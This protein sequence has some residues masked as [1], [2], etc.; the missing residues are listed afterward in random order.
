MPTSTERQNAINTALTLIPTNVASGAND[1][2]ISNEFYLLVNNIGDY[3][4]KFG[5]YSTNQTYRT[6]TIRYTDISG[7]FVQAEI[8]SYENLILTSGDSI[9]GT[10]ELH[11][12]VSNPTLIFQNTNTETIFDVVALS[13][14]ID[15]YSNAEGEQT[16]EIGYYT[17]SAGKVSSI[18]LGG[19]TRS[20]DVV[21]NIG[22]Q[23]ITDPDVGSF[24][25]SL[26]EIYGNLADNFPS[27]NMSENRF[28]D[29]VA[30]N[31]KY[32]P[33]MISNH[34]E[35]EA[36]GIVIHELLA[37]DVPADNSL[38]N[39]E[40][41]INQ[42]I[43]N[44][45]VEMSATG[46][47]QTFTGYEY[48]VGSDNAEEVATV[49][50]PVISDQDFIDSLHDSAGVSASE[51]KIHEASEETITV[52]K[53]DGTTETVTLNPAERQIV[54][55]E[56]IIVDAETGG[57]VISDVTGTTTLYGT[58]F[59]TRD[60]LVELADGTR[61][62]TSEVTQPVNGAMAANGVTGIYLHTQ[63]DPTGQIVLRQ[64]RI[65]EFTD[66]DGREHITT[67]T[68]TLG[69]QTLIQ[70]TV[71][72]ADGV[73]SES[74]A[75][76]VPNQELI[77]NL[78]FIGATAGG[79]LADHLADG[80]VLKGIAY[81]AIIT[82]ITDHFGSFTGYL[83][84]GGTLDAA[85][86]YA[87]GVEISNPVAGT[88]LE[89]AEI[90]GTFTKHLA[91]FSISALSNVIVDEVGDA[92]GL[93]G[94]VGG[95][96]FD[97]VAE[98]V[99]T[100]IL[101]GGLG[102]IFDS[103]DGGVYSSL[104][105]SGFDF[106]A[107]I[108]NPFLPNTPVDPDF[109]GPPP[110]NSTVGDFIQFQITNAFASYA[111]GRL[112][113]EFIEP[114]NQTG[115]IF[116]SIG[117]VA[118]VYAVN[119]AAAAAGAAT[120][121]TA[122]AIGN[123]LSFGVAGPVG[124]AI[125]AFIGTVAGTALG[126]VFGGGDNPQSW[127]HI[128]HNP[129]GEYNVTD[130]WAKGG[131]SD[132]IAF[133]LADAVTN[134]VNEIVDLTGGDLRTTSKA[135]G[136]TIGMYKSQFQFNFLGKEYAF[137][138]SGE[139][140]QKLAF[141]ILKNFDLVGG[142]AVL[143]RA[144]HNSD[145]NNLQEFKEDLE[146]AEAFM[147][148]LQNPTG[149]LA[150]MMDQPDS[151]L[152][153]S[154]SVVLQRAAELELHLPHE[155][156]LDGG[157]GEALLAQGYDPES[158]PELTSDTVIL[159]DPVTGE[160]T[161]LHHIIGPGYEI[162]RIEGTDGDDIINV[163]I[164]GNQISYVDALSGDDVIEG[165]DQPDV[166]VGGSGDDIINGNEGDDWL[167]G[168]EGEDEIN[169]NGGDDL[170]V[171]GAGNDY[172]IG[173]TESDKIYG[174]DGDDLIYGGDGED[175]LVGGAGND[176][177]TG[178]DNQSDAADK[179]Y[180]GDG[181]DIINVF[182]KDEVYLGNGN[183]SITLN[184]NAYLEIDRDI[185]GTKT[186]MLN[187]HSKIQFNRNISFYELDFQQISSD[188]LQIKLKGEDLTLIIQNFYQSQNNVTVKLFG[189]R[190]SDASPVGHTDFD[191]KAHLDG[192]V[193]IQ[194]S[195]VTSNYVDSVG[196]IHEVINGT[197]GNDIIHD[198][199]GQDGP[200]P[201]FFYG[202]GGN[203]SIRL[204]SGHNWGIGGTGDDTIIGGQKVDVIYGGS[205]NDTIRTSGHD[206]LVFGGSGNDDIGAG[207]GDDE[208]H[209]GLGNDIIDTGIGNDIVFGGAGND[210]I[211]GDMGDKV[212]NGDAGADV[213]DLT[214]TNGVNNISGGKGD[215]T[216]SGGSG[217]EIL[218]GDEDSDTIEGGAGDDEIFGGAGNDDLKGDTGD[219]LFI[220]YFSQSDSFDLIDG[221]E[222]NDTLQIHLA[223]TDLSLAHLRSDVL[224][225]QNFIAGNQIQQAY[226][227]L[228]I[229][230]FTLGLKVSNIES[231]EVYV[232]G[233]LQ[234]LSYN[235]I[236]GDVSGNI[237]DGTN[238]FDYIN[239]DAGNDIIS[240]GA[241]DDDL[242][243]GSG[244]DILYGENG[245][246]ILSGDDG[247]D[248]LFGGAG[249]DEIFGGA[250]DDIL[251]GGSGNDIIYGGAGDD[252]VAYENALNGVIV[253]LSEERALDE[254]NDSSDELYSIENVNGSAF[255]DTLIGDALDN[256]LT[257]G[258]GN[259]YLVGGAGTDILSGGVGAD[260]FSFVTDG[261]FN[262]IDII[263]DFSLIEGDSLK[264]DRLFE[265]DFS[266]DIVTDFIQITDNG[267][268]SFLFIDPNGGA[269][270]FQQ[271]STLQNITGITDEAQL[272]S[273]GFLV[274]DT[275]NFAPIAKDDSFHGLE[276][277]ILQGNVL[278]DNGSG[279]DA[280]P[281]NDPLHLYLETI[282]T[283]NGATVTIQSNGDFTYTPYQDFY[284]TDTFDYRVWDNQY[285]KAIGTVNI[286][287]ANFEEG[288]S[289][290]DSLNGTDVADYIYGYDSDDMLY[291]HEGD[292]SLFG[293]TGDD[294]L[295]G[296]IGN[297]TYVYHAGDSIDTFYDVGGHDKILLHGISKDD[298]EIKYF[299]NQDPAEIRFFNS[300]TDKIL[301]PFQGDLTAPSQIENIVF[302]DGT[303]WDIYA[304]QIAG[305]NSSNDTLYGSDRNDYINGRNGKDT[306][307]GGGGNDLFYGGSGNDKVYGEAGDDIFLVRSGTD[308]YYGGEGID[309]AW[310]AA[311]SINGVQYGGNNRYVKINLQNNNITKDGNAGET[312]NHQI[313]DVENVVTGVGDDTVR[314][315]DVSN[316]LITGEGN[317]ILDG[318]G[319]DDVLQGGSGNDKYDFDIGYGH[320]VITDTSG[321]DEIHFG[322]NI[323]HNDVSLLR[324][325]NDLEI[326]F[327]GSSTDK[328]TITNHYD[329]SL[330]NFVE[331]AVFNDG[332]EIV[333]N[334]F[335]ALN[336]IGASMDEDSVLNLSTTM[337]GVID[338]DSES[339]EITFTLD[340]L[341]TNSI[342]AMNNA[343]L[344]TGDSFTMQHIID[345]VVTFTP[346][347]DQ[348]GVFGFHFTVSDGFNVLPSDLFQITV[349]DVIDNIDGTPG[350]DVL[351]GTAG[352]DIIDGGT[353]LDNMTGAAGADT[354]V[355]GSDSFDDNVDIIADFD[356][357]E[358]DTI[359]LSEVLFDYDPLT[360]A[361]TDF[362]EI[363]SNG[364]DSVI[365]VD[366]DGGADNFIQIATLTQTSG[367]TDETLLES[368]GTLI[369]V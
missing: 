202:N 353:G 222:D 80:D 181:D 303:T 44:K 236:N 273:D 297:D 107:P 132:D 109:I 296:G 73:A 216:I 118:A 186:I 323:S 36:A 85:V 209:G 117:S 161:V 245:W 357:S 34:N 204:G 330:S 237:L 290:S 9:T 75:F 46:D 205:G 241:E 144:W 302:D 274:I 128:K 198:M 21:F 188:D 217:S 322:S 332:T 90:S 213:I 125:G 278:M 284:G 53:Q 327:V 87:R 93:E 256:F 275:E 214:L 88:L 314:G 101:T 276:N 141:K 349:N 339:S 20:A 84:S 133:N 193:P 358:G 79:L 283:S 228:A 66:S 244:D 49:D 43:A 359:D 246:D 92:L 312:N 207:N 35:L 253:D 149:I 348:I 77:G 31:M 218:S 82:T 2:V 304:G 151:A 225:L 338:T 12:N 176:T 346:N 203:D 234:T 289:N 136:A 63:T 19:G 58:T 71:I 140:I 319:G 28:Y 301:L 242:R 257:A 197:N 271:V 277:V 126:N 116:G 292:D 334:E 366:T 194:T 165:S 328:I 160:E 54:Q 220:Q 255:D 200:A 345:G 164:D 10:T 243:G 86:E 187:G 158:I 192:S 42:F 29:L 252:T 344:S 111:G 27:I 315:D 74:P 168:N 267:T 335:P 155:K 223:A 112:A 352:N 7:K 131:A 152:A 119:A 287:I 309:T 41:S 47:D 300:S 96:I 233:V 45:Q 37:G 106:S 356:P 337:L 167:H 341:P 39:D 32:N 127:A 191:L 138:N 285:N 121:T 4:Y 183:D 310:F 59:N 306:L 298:V 56:Q 249:D 137:D 293:G 308:K 122:A 260:I 224:R 279:I 178:E 98:S 235:E 239:G 177:I 195:L 22:S 171:G 104:L 15:R 175:R 343:L 350:D 163:N 230:L 280:D 261:V 123:I 99:T 336:N 60:K 347:S 48:M 102:L 3:A 212:I 196:R 153:Q 331:K 154:W 199:H 30:A 55:M 81:K 265:Y 120:T 170:I 208:V 363:T 368:N 113:G 143:M 61:L 326:S 272:F 13:G 17:F 100:G 219:D 299:S 364:G 201:S 159:T 26:D 354:F 231:L 281:D 135:Y 286:E 6:Y 268:D 169:G 105:S 146:I 95:E 72:D 184:G 16:G 97:V 5:N 369:T 68:Q 325:A 295:E 333:L 288:T 264:F 174:G 14:K 270:N 351:Y 215:D 365:S 65:T 173:S 263:Q 64:H 259:D 340:S 206:D 110:P 62:I 129:G 247:H 307:Y 266:T 221:G 232:E 108:N 52:Q 182:N 89:S 180:D 227:Q 229:T 70:E 114:E 250:G 57:I 342:L 147:H 305:S 361:I 145:A 360:D 94:T 211:T 134:F 103:V 172:L 262:D 313:Y 24:V 238:G 282:T 115:A 25:S 367:L 40:S 76:I 51:G 157:W 294:H 83:A 240:G 311:G 139:A 91:T 269:D 179:I 69:E 142:H 185:T 248:V 320:D 329:P 33:N 67:E 324:N 254:V 318:K 156:D 18:G 190:F 23:R 148:Y 316:L 11:S 362:V 321:L 291:G 78:Q 124:I 317:D 258:A 1:I 162:V 166:I 251:E 189:Q 8:N 355:F 38:F 50:E 226:T 150:M 130:S 210:T